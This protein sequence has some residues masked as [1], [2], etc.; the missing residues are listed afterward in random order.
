MKELEPNFSSFIFNVPQAIG[1]A[2]LRPDL[3]DVRHI[4]SLAAA[5]ETDAL[6]L[7]FLMFLFWR[8]K[9]TSQSQALIFTYFCLFLS[10]S[11]LITIGYVVNNLGAIVRYRSIVLPFLLS[12][13][14]CGIPWNKISGRILGNIKNKTNTEEMVKKN[15][16]FRHTP[17]KN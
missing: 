17:Q 3:S 16:Y 13:I 14:F 5:V 1:L 11:V 9:T 7:F 10:F 15:Q 4:F 8:R 6:L 2:I 12:P